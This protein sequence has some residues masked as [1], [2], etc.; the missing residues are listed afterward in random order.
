ML[1]MSDPQWNPDSLRDSVLDVRPGN[2]RVPE[3]Q[4]LGGLH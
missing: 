4:T 1:G 2:L 3:G